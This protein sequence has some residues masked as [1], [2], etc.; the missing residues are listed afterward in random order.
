MPILRFRVVM[1]VAVI[2][3][4]VPMMGCLLVCRH[5]ALAHYGW[6][7][8]EGYKPEFVLFTTTPATKM[9]ALGA[10]NG[11]VQATILRDGKRLWIAG[12]PDPGLYSTADYPLGEYCW[13]MDLPQYMEWLRENKELTERPMPPEEYRKEH[14]PKC[15]NL[16]R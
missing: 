15:A 1:V 14:W 12:A 4:L 13:T 16:K 9:L 5:M 2:A 7:I 6:A 8:E 10:F 3:F 11:H